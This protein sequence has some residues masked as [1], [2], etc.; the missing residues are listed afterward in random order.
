MEQMIILVRK[1]SAKWILRILVAVLQTLVG[2][3]MIPR[4]AGETRVMPA[5][6]MIQ[7]IMDYL[8]TRSAF[9]YPVAPQFSFR[10]NS[11]HVAT[12]MR[13][14]VMVQRRSH[15]RQRAVQV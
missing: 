1:I 2:I 3:G 11:I 8:T 4:L 10:N 6:C 14:A 13:I 7:L 15:P 9:R 12:K 5:S